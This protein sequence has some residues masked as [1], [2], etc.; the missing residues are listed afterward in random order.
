[1][2]FLNNQCFYIRVRCASNYKILRRFTMSRIEKTNNVKP[3]P[4]DVKPK[5][6]H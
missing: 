5:Q 4:R 1:M 2:Q 6:T 3:Q